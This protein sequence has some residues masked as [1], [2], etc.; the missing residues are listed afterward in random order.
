[1]KKQVLCAGLTLG[2]MGL[3]S[4]S[5]LQPPQPVLEAQVDYWLPICTM[6]HI[7]PQEVEGIPGMGH[8]CQQHVTLWV[9]TPFVDS[10]GFQ[11]WVRTL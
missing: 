7:V 1:M 5:A 3:S 8:Y 10:R 9:A 2:L 4:A 11:R 6:K